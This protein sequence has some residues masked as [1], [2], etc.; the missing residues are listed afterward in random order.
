[1]TINGFMNYL[2]HSIAGVIPYHIANVA[3]IEIER[4]EFYSSDC[5]RWD[6]EGKGNDCTVCNFLLQLQQPTNDVL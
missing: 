1:M 2:M 6:S 3:G 4:L 5:Q